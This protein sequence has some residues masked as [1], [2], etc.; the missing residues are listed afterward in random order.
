MTKYVA[1]QPRSIK[2]SL[3]STGLAT[4]GGGGRGGSAGGS[5][6]WTTTGR[7]ATTADKWT[8]GVQP[9]LLTA[10]LAPAQGRA[11]VARALGHGARLT[12]WELRR[13]AASPDVGHMVRTA[14]RRCGSGLASANQ[15]LAIMALQWPKAAVWRRLGALRRVAPHHQ[16]RL[17]MS[18]MRGWTSIQT[19]A[20]KGYAASGQA[21]RAMTAPSTTSRWRTCC[22]CGGEPGVRPLPAAMASSST[23]RRRAQRSKDNQLKR[24][25]SKRRRVRHR[26]LAALR[27]RQ[28]D[29]S[30]GPALRSATRPSGPYRWW[31]ASSFERT[32]RRASDA[33]CEPCVKAKTTRSGGPSNT[34][35]VPRWSWAA[36]VCGP[37]RR[38]VVMHDMRPRR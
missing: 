18:D 5:A 35:T 21:G 27:C 32:T 29:G 26:A 20:V 23:S 1:L 37:F 11:P 36:C 12:A 10:E 6:A 22:T 31:T 16:R 25:A 38:R 34:Y 7:L 15:P 8:G 9:A 14:P 2:T 30:C 13:P 24:N 33:L 28:G 17:Y 19:F 4:D 3:P